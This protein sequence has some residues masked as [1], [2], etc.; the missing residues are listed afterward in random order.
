MVCF[1]HTTDHN[2]D[3][4]TVSLGLSLCDAEE[5]LE[6]LDSIF[7]RV[8]F[9]KNSQN[10][11]FFFDVKVLASFANKA[12]HTELFEVVIANGQRVLVLIDAKFGISANKLV[13][14][15]EIQLLFIDILS[16]INKYLY[17]YILPICYFR[18]L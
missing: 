6:V 10:F 5:V 1:D 4:T 16:K 9:I 13:E 2:I 7:V 8:K 12:L 3:Q 18:T 11:G 17:K 14:E 15:L